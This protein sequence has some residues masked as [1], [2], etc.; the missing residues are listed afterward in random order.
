MFREKSGFVIAIVAIVGMASG[1]AVALSATTF[2]TEADHSS[3]QNPS[4]HTAQTANQTPEN[5]TIG[6]L[7]LTDVTVTNARFESV[8]RVG[9]QTGNRT[10]TDVTVNEMNV[11]ATLRNVTLQNV[12]VRDD[13]LLNELVGNVTNASV[14]VPNQT[15]E[16]GTGPTQP[17][18]T[19]DTV[20]LQNRVVEG[21]VVH[22]ALVTGNVSGNITVS[23]GATADAANQTASGP[24]AMEVGSATVGDIVRVESVSVT[25]LSVGGGQMTT[26]DET[27]ATANE[28]TDADEATAET[29][30]AATN[31]AAEA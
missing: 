12:T 15:G 26:S 24:A 18:V 30:T 20:S 9:T 13:E 19:V 28:T 21:L 17:I 3:L 11:T 14:R 23:D 8:T 29:T 2:A 10:F 16:N 1:P 7:V 31:D 27:T 5:F 22:D 6:T 4:E 25:G